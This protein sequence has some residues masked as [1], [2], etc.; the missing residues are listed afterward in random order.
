MSSTRMARES[1]PCR[2]RESNKPPTS[3]IPMTSPRPFGLALLLAL[4]MAIPSS[5]IALPIATQEKT[6]EQSTDST[7]QSDSDKAKD[8]TNTTEDDAT[9]IIPTETRSPQQTLLTFL[10]A[11]QPD[12]N[13]SKNADLA[14]P[15]KSLSTNTAIQGE[16]KNTLVQLLNW[17]GW[18]PKLVK[19]LVPGDKF[20]ENQWRV[21]PFK[22]S[23][24]PG[25]SSQS[26]KLQKALPDEYE[27]YLTKSA[28]NGYQFA[29][30][31]LEVSSLDSIR[32]A[33]R[34]IRRETG[35]T[36]EIN[37]LSE[38]VDYYAPSYL[39]N[40][41]VFLEIWQWIGL[42]LIIF[43]GLMADLIT[44]T[45]MGL[46]V[47]RLARNFNASIE[48]KRIR[49]AV[50][51]IGLLAA[52]LTWLGLLTVLGL[53][54]MAFQVLQPV[55]TLMFVTAI[56]WCLWRMV[57][58]VGDVVVAKA[59]RTDTKLDDVLVPMVRKTIKVLIVVFALLNLAPVFGLDLGPLLAAIG[60]GTLGLSFAFK[61]TLEN[62]FGSITVILDRPF[63]VGDWVVCKGIEGTVEAVGMR[64]TRIRTFYNSLVTMPNSVLITNEV[65][66]YGMRKYRRWSTS[67]GVTYDT[68]PVTI[69]AFC[70]AIREVIRQHP[71][72]RK[73]YYQIWLNAFGDS[74]LE[75]MLY[76][77]WEAPDWQTEL[78]ERHRFML[79]IIMIAEEMGVEFAFPTQT[80]HLRK[81]EN[82]PPSHENEYSSMD[83]AE[84]RRSARRAVRKITEPAP[85]KKEKPPRYRFTTAEETAE[86]DQI[87][88]T[89]DASRAERRLNRQEQQ[90]L[91]PQSGDDPESTD[92]TEQRDAGGE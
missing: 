19:E 40:T 54:L 59:S 78:R 11:T 84:A 73:D 71:Y 12:S 81:D 48:E 87:Q 90:G 72:T 80:L 47:R 52:A 34:R 67:L 32:E 21:F 77:F 13:S 82:E 38:W 33:I 20:E 24:A 68:D 75:I 37:N 79:E 25:I 8:G 31:S 53:P 30:R 39:L 61:D 7:K 36:T 51:G 49:H 17:Q 3:E 6:A 89:E 46:I 15:L 83:A 50:R 88:N 26:Q 55:A 4:L 65:D 85:W 86:I 5:A 42:A 27:L 91:P 29:A 28:T 16:I 57:D 64:S 62:F 9:S 14:L 44:S 2:L 45:L 43:L 1:V 35:D 74:S 60:I 92:F 58:L 56:A 63:Q 18:N 41:F 22:N 70:E 23:K 10:S 69:D 76:L 66:N